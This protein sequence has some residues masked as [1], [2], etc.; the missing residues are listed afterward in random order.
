MGKRLNRIGAIFALLAVAISCSA[1]GALADP[2]KRP[3][4]GNQIVSPPDIYSQ[5]GVLNVTLDYYTSVDQWGRTLFCYVT[6]DGMEGPTLHVNPGDKVK[7]KLRDKEPGAPTLGSGVETVSGGGIACGSTT[8]MPTS[9]NIHFHGLNI[10]PRCHG[11]EVIHTIVNPGETFDYH[12]TVP[13][14]E[15]PGM[16]WYHA[17]VHGIA[18]PAVQGGASGAIEVEG[19][20]NLQP[21]VQGLPQR[22][23]IFRDQ[24]LAYPPK[25]H[26]VQQLVPFWDVSMNFV[27][28]SFP[29]YKAGVIKMQAGAQ[30]FWRF[31]NASADTVADI[32][33]LYDKKPQPLQI[34]AFD[35]VPTGSHD[36]R[37]QGTIITQND[38]L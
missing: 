20:A 16:Y 22:F 14:D 17:H 34:V 28:V 1:T 33:L 13:K 38:I 19:I 3:Q 29:H 7:I 36:G 18:S 31:V 9:I 21:A 23:L 30:E 35:G 26:L 15:P 2:C 37:H 32:V 4:E 5:D 25:H 6:P 11:D 10:K 8:M 27:P 12:F 24:P